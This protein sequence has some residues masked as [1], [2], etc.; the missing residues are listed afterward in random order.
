M[1]VYIYIYIYKWLK[2]WRPV[3]SPP[4]CVRFD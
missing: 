4:V 2:K 1:F 3:L